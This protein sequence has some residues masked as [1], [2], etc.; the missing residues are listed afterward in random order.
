M[1]LRWA[2]LGVVVAAVGTAAGVAATASSTPQVVTPRTSAFDNGHWVTSWNTRMS[3]TVTPRTQTVTVRNTIRATLGGSIARVE[4]TNRFGTGPVRL[5]ASLAEPAGKH[6]AEAPSSVRALSF[7]G[8]RT[9]T[10]GAGDTALS[11]PI[12]VLVAAGRDVFIDVIADGVTGPITAHWSQRTSYAADG[13]HPEAAPGGM[14]AGPAWQFADRL[15][16]WAP[17]RSGAVVVVG[18]SMALGFRTPIDSVAEWPAALARRYIAAGTDEAVVDDSIVATRL[19]APS[20][21]Q[22][23]MLDRELSDPLAIPGV[24]TV[25]LS[26]LINDIQQSPHVYAP[27]QIIAGIK[28]FVDVAHQHGIRVAVATIT[29]YR[30]FPQ[31]TARGEACRAA[32]NKWIRATS[33]VDAVLDFDQA[34]RDPAEPSRILPALDSGDHLHP[35]A[36]GQAAMADSIDLSLIG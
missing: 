32:V 5:S 7:D 6:G 36:A 10:L 8:Q 9:V 34:L 22:P 2:L 20:G 23:S 28:L 3:S 21:T 19:L 29:P 24:R 14:R 4:L 27:R 33:S 31:Y 25:V 17:E 1:K 18:A 16:V 13:A 35:D 15:D 30:G 12:T 11:D 26:E